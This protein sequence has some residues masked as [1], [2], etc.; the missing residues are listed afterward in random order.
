MVNF[1]FLYSYI[2]HTKNVLARLKR[3]IKHFFIL[4]KRLMIDNIMRK[5]IFYKIKFD[6]KGH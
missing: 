1:L 2:T 4:L 3:N 5:Q 6:P